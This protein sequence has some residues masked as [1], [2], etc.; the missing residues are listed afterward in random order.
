MTC[1]SIIG[2]AAYIPD[3]LTKEQYAKLS[4]TKADLKKKNEKKFFVGKNAETLTEVDY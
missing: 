1:H 4:V 3:G 2:K